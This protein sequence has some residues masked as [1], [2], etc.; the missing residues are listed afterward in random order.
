[1]RQL[2]A[3]T[4]G[5]GLKTAT[6]RQLEH[7]SIQ[8]GLDPVL[9][10]L[11]AWEQGTRV[12]LITTIHGMTKLC[13]TQL[14]GIEATFWDRSGQPHDVWLSHEPPEACT[15]VVYR[16]GASRGFANSCRFADY[17]GTG[18]P[19]KK[20]PST[21]I[22]K[23]ALAGA[24]RLA[25]SDLLAG[26]YAQEEMDQAMTPAQEPPAPRRA[27][28]RESAP[29][30]KALEQ[31][32]EQI[33]QQLRDKGNPVLAERS[34][35]PNEQAMSALWNRARELG[36]TTVGWDTLQAQ[37]QNVSSAGITPNV[38]LQLAHQLTPEKVTVLNSGEFT[39]AAPVAA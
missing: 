30:A 31:E 14:D 20:M 5:R 10:E 38:A 3:E 6:L 16:K 34:F 12:T 13:A 22:R 21:M 8:R 39:T 15:V 18:Q 36:M 9:G 32:G 25:F 23:C 33:L 37:I 17:A 1:M 28:K 35:Q 11:L 29:A 7:V 4:V 19:W 27:P 26:L 2:V 24:L